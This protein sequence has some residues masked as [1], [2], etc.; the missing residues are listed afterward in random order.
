MTVS[1]GR[2]TN[3][4]DHLPP[5]SYFTLN[6]FNQ[7]YLNTPEEERGHGQAH[8]NMPSPPT[9]QQIASGLASRATPAST[10]LPLP[11][12]IRT[13][14]H[15]P[16]KS[17]SH[18]GYSS[19]GRLHATQSVSASSS[20]SSITIP[21]PSNQPVPLR[22]SLK[23]T[24]TN[25]S[26]TSSLAPS[27]STAPPSLQSVGNRRGPP[28]SLSFPPKVAAVRNLFASLHG[29]AR[30]NSRIAGA[31]GLSTNDH[32]G[33]RSDDGGSVLSDNSR[34]RRVGRVR[35][36]DDEDEDEDRVRRLGNNGATSGQRTMPAPSPSEPSA[37]GTGIGAA[38][39]SVSGADTSTSMPLGLPPLSALPARFINTK[40]TVIKIFHRVSIIFS[41]LT[42]YLGPHRPDKFLSCY[43][44]LS[45][46]TDRIIA[47]VNA[48]S[49]TSPPAISI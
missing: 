16:R 25:S 18:Y 10:S 43:G 34:A 23:K 29:H 6:A 28:N 21:S 41:N 12:R 26:A 15:R 30:H 48:R 2:P 14:S 49:I 33:A 38:A 13:T 8:L 44:W 47:V 39:A 36:S 37:N 27:S 4:T 9:I 11:P 24:S 35:F 17:S 3:L 22:S 32:N 20:T 31:T 46:L 42:K 19:N 7:T 1:S 45:P 40:K 5:F